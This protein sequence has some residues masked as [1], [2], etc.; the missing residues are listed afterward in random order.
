MLLGPDLGSCSTLTQAVQLMHACHSLI[1]RSSLL[2]LQVNKL[3]LLVFLGAFLGVIFAGVDIGLAI[4]IGI[5]VLI[6]L[7]RTAFPKTVQLGQLPQT[8]VYR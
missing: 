5:S 7:W 8:Y 6:A 4:G 3:D 2:S 1:F